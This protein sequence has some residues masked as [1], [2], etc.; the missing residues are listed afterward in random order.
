MVNRKIFLI[1]FLSILLIL[2]LSS[3]DYSITIVNY[4]MTGTLDRTVYIANVDTELDLS[5]LETVVTHRDG[6][7][8]TYSW[9]LVVE[10]VESR[11][12]TRDA[13]WQVIHSIDF[14]EPGEYEVEIFFVWRYIGRF[15]SR[16]MEFSYKFYIQVIDG[17]DTTE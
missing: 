13:G 17:E 12:Y 9:G 6:M 16:D 3:C 15:R 10:P 8:R 7:T 5:G 4:E 14:T 11:E 2:L 1:S